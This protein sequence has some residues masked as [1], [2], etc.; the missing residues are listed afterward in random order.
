MKPSLRI[1]H[2]ARFIRR[3]HSVEV[4]QHLQRNAS[5]ILA[6]GVEHTAEVLL[7]NLA[8][9]I[10]R[11]DLCDLD[12]LD[13]G[14]GVRF[15]QALINRA[16]PFK[17]YTGIDVALPLIQW[18]KEN[19]ETKDERF[20]FAHWNVRNALYNK[21]GVP[22]QDCDAFPISGSYDLLMGFSLFTH[23]GPEDARQM[24][25]LARQVVRPG[26]WL[27]FSAFCDPTIRD[28]EDRVPHQPLLKAYYNKEYLQRIITDTH[29]DV[30]SY[31]ER[32]EYV[33][34]S[35]LCRPVEGEQ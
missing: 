32:G 20:R 2:S 25:K 21:T 8:V 14:C 18:L 30:I 28:F 4:P 17:S 34:S 29:W 23:L 26:G 13:L 15:T 1:D 12:M 22:M 35:F 7:N 24:L 10:G 31:Q 27:F 11:R 16:I 19:V 6:A 3:L 5:K 9:R 33:M